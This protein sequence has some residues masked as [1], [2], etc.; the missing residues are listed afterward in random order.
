MPLIYE[1]PLYKAMY[2]DLRIKDLVV[3]YS[4]T[5]PKSAYSRIRDFLYKKDFIHEQ[6]SGYHS[7]KPMT[8][9]N[10]INLVDDMKES[11]PWLEACVNKFE[12]TNVS[13]NYDILNLFSRQKVNI[14]KFK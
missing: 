2:F 12:I 3:H 13:E 11:L 14:R 6:Y 5:N 10:V 7:N 8:D 1:T 4:A 9:L